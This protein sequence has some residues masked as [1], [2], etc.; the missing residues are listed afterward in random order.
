M[1]PITVI[2]QTVLSWQQQLRA[3]RDLMPL[4]LAAHTDQADTSAVEQAHKLFAT[5]APE[6]FLNR[7]AP[8]DPNDPLLLQVLPQAQELVQHDDFSRDP[9]GDHAAI[10]ADGVLHKY[11]G[12]VLL[13]TTGACAIHCRYCFRRHFPYSE[14][15]IG[16]QRLQA[17]IDYI[18]NDDSITE[19]ILSGGDPLTLSNGHLAN[20]TNQLNSIA[21]VKR[22]RI[23]TRI[24]VVL[25]DRIDDGFIDWLAHLEQDVSIVIHA[26]HANE[27]D[28]QVLS[29]LHRMH[30]TGTVLLNQSVLLKGIN[31]SAADL[32][33]L[34]QRLFEC[35][36]IPYY[37]HLLDRV[38]G[39]LHFDV[40]SNTARDLITTLQKTLPG[41]L[42]PKLV[43]EN[44]GH[45][46]KSPV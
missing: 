42:V 23:H 43:R 16:G 35:R 29:T 27:L 40:D 19:V 37:L 22:L 33:A 7:I 18:K 46:S 30:Q 1:P 10:K 28:D 39:A 21:H 45:T 31:D 20:I 15:H 5:R 3:V 38:E 8:G 13:I 12:R 4:H 24:P 11:E 44:A 6:A 9:V 26:N 32:S 17:A 36:V 34:S 25:P 41:Y 14:S 2:K